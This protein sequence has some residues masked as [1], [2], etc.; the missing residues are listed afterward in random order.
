MVI[1]SLGVIID[2][3]FTDF[4]LEV[5]ELYYLQGANI[6]QISEFLK[7]DE[8]RIIEI[9]SDP[10]YRALRKPFEDLRKK[11]KNA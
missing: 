8:K 1:E 9:L 3:S 10:Y 7:K 6:T 5:T 11:N 2:K 4:E